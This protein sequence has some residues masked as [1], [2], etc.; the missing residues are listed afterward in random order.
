MVRE[1]TM[2]DAFHFIQTT[3]GQC[4]LEYLL[5][6]LKSYVHVGLIVCM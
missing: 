3:I 5:L 2:E 1:F 4:L 6:V